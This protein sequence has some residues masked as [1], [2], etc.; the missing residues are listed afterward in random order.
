MNLMSNDTFIK[1]LGYVFVVF[2][3]CVCFGGLIWFFYYEKIMI[4]K[5]QMFFVGILIALVLSFYW[6]KFSSKFKKE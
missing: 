6:D 4:N 3:T 5:F 1:I 2:G